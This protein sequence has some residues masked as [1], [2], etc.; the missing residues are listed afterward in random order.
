MTSVN[1]L[2]INIKIGTEVKKKIDVGSLSVVK[3]RDGLNHAKNAANHSFNVG[4]SRN[5]V[6]HA[7]NAA[8][9]N[10]NVMK[11]I[12]AANLIINARNVKDSLA[13]VL[14]VMN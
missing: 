2:V 9:H 12:D 6:N 13:L 10:L 11:S 1:N 7:M 5:G 3:S 4:K 14:L 8:N